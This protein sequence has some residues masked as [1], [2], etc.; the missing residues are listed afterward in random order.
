TGAFA[1]ALHDALPI[2]GL[3]QTYG[4]GLALLAAFQLVAHLLP[5]VH[6]AQPG[7][8]DGR[9]VYEHILRPVFRLNEAVAFLAVE[10]LYGSDRHR[11]PS[12]KENG[13]PPNRLA[14]RRITIGRSAGPALADEPKEEQAEP[15]VGR[16]H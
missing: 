14:A 13:P 12:Q 5:F 1:L 11:R 6:I 8:L 16:P 3:L 7:A 9:D 15:G 4:R 2:L 10:P